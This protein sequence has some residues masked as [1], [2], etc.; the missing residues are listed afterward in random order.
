MSWSSLFVGACGGRGIA[1]LSILLLNPLSLLS[2]A[3][4]YIDLWRGQSKRIRR[5]ED[6]PDNG[7]SAA[8]DKGSNSLIV[9]SAFCFL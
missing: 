2:E 4:T 1:G 8:A 5:G 7:V 9:H 6:E 3:N